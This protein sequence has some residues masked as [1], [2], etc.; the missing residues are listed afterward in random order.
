[1]FRQI[2]YTQ[3]KWSRLPLLA[4]VL[5]CFALPLLSAQGIRAD[6]TGYWNVQYILN[7]LQSVGVFYPLLAAGI[8][9]VLGLTTWA[10]DHRGKHIYALSLPVPRWH[11]VLLRFGA[12]ALLILLPTL[13][14]WVS[15]LITASVTKLPPGIQAYPTMLAARFGL[16]ALIAFGAFFAVSAGTNKT[17]GFM[18]GTLA[19]L[20]LVQLLAGMLEINVRFLE[21]VLYQVIIWP[22]PLEI[23]SGHWMLFDA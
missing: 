15:A 16:A 5:A 1:M 10:A 17:A 23:F 11:Y 14:L 22:G 6:V 2:L 20:I 7:S 19:A 8:G 9:L 12:G 21:T 4:F 18:L 3:W 13:A